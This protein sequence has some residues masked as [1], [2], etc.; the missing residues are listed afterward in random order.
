MFSVCLW[1]QRLR[2]CSP[3]LVREVHELLS[4]S[5]EG[6]IV[7]D[8]SPNLKRQENERP[9][10]STSSESSL[11]SRH[12]EKRQKIVRP[13]GIA[14]VPKM[15]QPSFTNFII[16]RPW[17]KRWM[18][19]LANW[20]SDAAGYR[21]LGLRYDAPMYRQRQALAIVDACIN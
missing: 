13:I 11:T 2:C 18:T 20:Y 1:K 15:S 14:T 6:Q 3:C 10:T 9:C 7:D 17:L 5:H 19:P 21:K 12:K 16:K 4:Q 8:G